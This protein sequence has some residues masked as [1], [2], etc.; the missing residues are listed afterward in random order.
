MA[1]T[2]MQKLI[3]YMEEN[4]HLTE[5]TKYEFKTALEEERQQIINT[6]KWG[7]IYNVRNVSISPE[8]F[9]L[10]NYGR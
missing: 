10:D 3:D 9:F 5:E 6:F 7:T 1:K 4:Y 2:A 8:Q